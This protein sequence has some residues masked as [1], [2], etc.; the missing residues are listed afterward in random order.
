VADDETLIGSFSPLG[1]S[2]VLS[3]SMRRSQLSLHIRDRG[4]AAELARELGAAVPAQGPPPPA[5]ARP[6]VAAAGTAWAVLREARAAPDSA[7]F[8]ECVARSL[9]EVGDPWRIL[10]IWDDDADPDPA[11]DAGTDD[12][13]DSR[14]V[15]VPAREIRVAAA[16]LLQTPARLAAGAGRWAAWLV[17]DAWERRCFV[18]AALLGRLLPAEHGELRA[19]AVLAAA[20]EAG[21]LGKAAEDAAVDLWG[22]SA[23][24]CS[25]GAAG[26]VGELL[27]WAGPAGVDAL[28]VL[29][30]SLPPAWQQL[31]S[32]AQRH[33]RESTAPLPLE[34]LAA[35]GARVSDQLATD[36]L[37]ALLTKRIDKLEAL[38][39]R[40]VFD[41]GRELHLAL[42]RDGGLLSGIR[43]AV[44]GD[45]AALAAL[46]GGLPADPREYMDGLIS[47][48][49]EEP[50]EWHS[51]ISF[52]R[53]VEEIVRTA[54][55][56]SRAAEHARES[57]P[58]GS[59]T[60]ARGSE[61]LARHVAGSWDS[62]FAEA[63]SAFPRP[64]SH[65]LLALLDRLD[66][67]ARWALEH[68]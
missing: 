48:A 67:L 61:A 27:F 45:T 1:G 68:G 17:A 35:V 51:Q 21:P 34:E 54:R 5:P 44:A 19:S 30:E 14:Q 59:A 53:S 50:M 66:P 2:D 43:A 63:T 64:F 25:A 62:L 20:L 26:A 13:G 31:A 49:G 38:R 18:E 22:G 10:D 9:S 23:G 56:L 36:R 39:K 37:R 24:A 65:P 57:S 52:L 6:H 4:F 8:G 41:S 15:R 33:F 7:G 60:L 16:A 11:W 12:A 3:A 42:F 58:P 29:A 28:D 55:E 47:A 46:R 32:A 40:F